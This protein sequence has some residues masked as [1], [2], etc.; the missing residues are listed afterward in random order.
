MVNQDIFI[1][2]HGF[3]PSDYTQALLEGELRELHEWAPYGAAIKAHISR[4]NEE[5]QATL[6]ILSR[7]PS[8]FV[9][10]KGTSLRDVSDRLFL[11]MKKKIGKWKA[12]RFGKKSIER[13]VYEHDVA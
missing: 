2:Y 13:H 12:R 7:G 4:K 6:R 1:Q 9:K 3:H 11:Q 5:L 8:F 10:A